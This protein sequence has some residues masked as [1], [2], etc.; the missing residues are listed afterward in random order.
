MIVR[1]AQLGDKKRLRFT[2]I[3]KEVVDMDNRGDM[4]QMLYMNR[5]AKLLKHA[6]WDEAEDK[7]S[8]KRA[9][10]LNKYHCG[11]LPDGDLLKRSSCTSNHVSDRLFAEAE[12]QKYQELMPG[13]KPT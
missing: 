9:A 10:R 7:S 5:V 2:D 1:L 11:V 4:E 8:K 12:K 6:T 13:I 3:E